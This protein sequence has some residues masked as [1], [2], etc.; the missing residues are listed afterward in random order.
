MD[1]HKK[2]EK[3]LKLILLFSGLVI[4]GVVTFFIYSDML[5][6]M[7]EGDNN[8][9]EVKELEIGSF[10]MPEGYGTVQVEGYAQIQP[11]MDCADGCDAQTQ[12]G[13]FEFVVFTITKIN[14]D[15][16]K[17]YFETNPDYSTAWPQIGL[18]CY[19]DELITYDNNADITGIKNYELSTIAS[20]KIINSSQDKL[21]RLELEKLPLTTESDA[22][23]DCYSHFNRISVLD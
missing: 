17:E 18:G 8:I 4:V 16:L 21:I 6:T 2:R 5:I 20:T 15:A 23:V 19:L 10:S 3:V 9:N 12:K 1:K 11:T 7:R 22:P 14:N 13:M